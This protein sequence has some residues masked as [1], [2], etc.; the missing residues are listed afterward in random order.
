MDIEQINPKEAWARMSDN[1]KSALYLDVRTKAEFDQGHP[2]GAINIP[3][4]IR[5]E[6]DA[7]VAN[8]NFLEEA[9]KQ[10][11]KSKRLVIGCQRGGRSQ[12]ACEIMSEAGY[13]DLANV[14]GG[15]GGT[16]E[17]PGWAS[18]ELPTE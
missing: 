14:A 11:E 10:I 12:K 3:V 18:L 13:K 9:E 1:E 4:R 2:K 6:N 8:P 17:Q 15:F 16:P 5:D 7:M